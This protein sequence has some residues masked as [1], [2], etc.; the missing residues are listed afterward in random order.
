MSPYVIVYAFDEPPAADLAQTFQLADRLY[1]VHSQERPSLWVSR[2]SFHEVEAALAVAL[3]A[4]QV[5]SAAL[6]RPS[7]LRSGSGCS[8]NGAG[9]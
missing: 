4:G 2:S 1:L 5:R 8:P 6:L 9:G 3:A 7:R